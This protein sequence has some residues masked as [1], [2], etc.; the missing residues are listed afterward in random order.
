MAMRSF[1]A[2]T[3]KS[4]MHYEGIAPARPQDEPRDRHGLVRAD[5]LLVSQGL[6]PSRT[7][8]Q[9]MI[10]AGRVRCSAGRIDKPSHEL[11]ADAALHVT[12]D[13]NDRYVSRGGIKL[14]G[15][16]SHTGID[17]RGRVCLDVGQSTGGFTDCLI[18]S[19][20]TR[21]VGVDVG[22]TQL[23][24]R[25]R[26]DARITCIE[27]LNCRTLAHDDLG[28]KMPDEG[29]GLIVADVSF[30][31]LTLILPQLPVLLTNPGDLL[32]LVKPQFEV[33][34]EHIGKGGI[35]TD[36]RLYP[37]VRNKI[38]DCCTLHHLTVID[39]F[40]SPI[41]GTDGN[42]EFFLHARHAQ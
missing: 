24:P 14:A 21:V 19:G 39:W 23:H 37:V 7:A 11:P 20:A 3:R 17:V 42:R 16:L 5:A 4:E 35:V 26:G 18:Q 38:T 27:G 22:R 28:D 6:A 29:F 1:H 36:T 2:R 25:L 33:G 41:T 13:D 10:A 30:I 40:D 34:P 8:A 9:R 32:L 31:S 12:E 15:A